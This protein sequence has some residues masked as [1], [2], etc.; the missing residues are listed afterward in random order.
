MYRAAT[1][2]TAW[3]PVLEAL[4]CGMGARALTVQ[5]LGCRSDELQC[6][7]Y[8]DSDLA[9]YA[10]G[11][12]RQWQANELRSRPA[13]LADPSDGLVHGS[14]WTHSSDTFA[15]LPTAH[16]GFERN[17]RSAKIFVQN[18]HLMLLAEPG[19]CT[20]LAITWHQSRAPLATMERNLVERLGHHLRDAMHLYAK[21]RHLQPAVLVGKHLLQSAQNPCWLVGANASV[22]SA[23]DAAR[24]M[25]A[26]GARVQCADGKLR[27]T[28]SG[29]QTA[30]ERELTGLMQSS[31]S[32]QSVLTLG[33]P[34]SAADATRAWLLLRRLNQRVNAESPA[35]PVGSA[36]VLVTVFDLSCTAPLDATTLSKVFGFTP[37]AGR[38][39]ALV[40]KGLTGDEMAERLRLKQ[41]TVRTHV[42]QILT[43]LGVQRKSDAIRMLLHGAALKVSN[44]TLSTQ[45]TL[46]AGSID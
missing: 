10:T 3:E 24:E 4:C 32:K 43:K 39:A 9:S 23:N 31:T 42:R 41:T 30:F 33:G 18:T 46:K 27:L 29:D 37:A 45:P 26:R 17:V 7:Q 11:V 2:A 28:L 16:R 20:A 36:L 21:L 34:S 13:V 6:L 22:F 35:P 19:E 12:L 5:T 15:Q 40:A 8:G 14:R 1:M 38:V 44:G 25:Q